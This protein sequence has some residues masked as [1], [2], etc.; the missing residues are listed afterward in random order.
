[1]AR[2]KY[3]DEPWVQQQQKTIIRWLNTKLQEDTDSGITPSSSLGPNSITNLH[4]DLQNGLV[5]IKLIN[6][7]IY[8]IT[9][10]ENH[11]MNN[12]KLYYLS[13]IYK[14]PT[15]KLQKLENLN[16]F[17]KFINLILKIN[18]CNI[19]ADNIY[20]GDLKLNLGLIWSLFLF[21]TSTSFTSFKSVTPSFIEI[22]KILLTW[23]NNILQKRNC[24]IS[25]F[26]KDWS[27]EI[28]RPDRILCD[29]LQHYSL[30]IKLD[31]GKN[32]NLKNLEH[33]LNYFQTKLGIAHLVDTEDFAVLVPEE[34]CIVAFLVELFKFFEIAGDHKLDEEALEE[35]EAD[36]EF[37]EGDYSFDELIE[38]TIVTSRLK[39]KYETRSLRFLNKTNTLISQLNSEM[40]LLQEINR[41]NQLAKDLDKCL[42]LL[43]D[44]IETSTMENLNKFMNFFNALNIKVTSLINICQTFQNFRANIKPDLVYKDYPDLL[45]L[46]KTVRDNLQ[47]LDIVYYPSSKSLNIET[48]SDKFESLM[49]LESKFSGIAT[50]LLSTLQKS[51]SKFNGQLDII[52]QNDL[53]NQT[54]EV[55][56]K[57][58][59]SR[60]LDYVDYLVTFFDKLGY[61]E[62]LFKVSSSAELQKALESSYSSE[63]SSFH[64]NARSF[65]VF[66]QLFMGQNNYLNHFELIKFLKSKVVTGEIQPSNVELFVKL[67]PTRS[68][69][70]LA[71]S[72]I[73][74]SSSEDNISSTSFSSTTSASDSEDDYL[75]DDLQQKLDSQLSGTSQRVYDIHDFIEQFENGFKV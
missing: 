61:F 8:E 67:I 10:N 40:E 23:I 15:F 58:W 63:T 64:L 21:G 4:E 43:H 30:P 12:S 26:N 17:L 48:I 35:E 59:I 13:P 41:N 38:L 65:R 73:H 14:K 33:V 47:E 7:L 62:D 51:S 34:K 20:E 27:I 69:A 71:N 56:N 75:F 6:R 28:N 19:S 1:M 44:A 57:D 2:P 32:K 37:S 50:G 66:K 18:V 36:D 11:P 9:L 52:E 49:S 25:N 46:V 31:N 55:E 24:S 54:S 60:C 39:N 16:D 53:R 45:N 74:S 70:S 3:V 68:V 42:D 5:L 72:S 29:I 22:K